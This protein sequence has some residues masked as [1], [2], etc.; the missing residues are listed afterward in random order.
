MDAAMRTPAR[1]ARH[2]IH[3][4]LVPV[5]IGL[6]LFAFACDLL[7]VLGSGASLWFTLSFYTMI[8]G[9]IGAIVAA[10]PGFIDMLALSG[11]PKRLALTHMAMNL[12]VVVLFAVNLGMRINGP[13]VMGLPLALSVV[14]I[15]LL[16]VSGWLGGQMVYVHRVGVEEA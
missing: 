12:T 6:W 14:A 7:F 16:A 2:P 9:L 15:T 5:P 10:I 3:P 1:I 4:M 8:G 11:A 13:E